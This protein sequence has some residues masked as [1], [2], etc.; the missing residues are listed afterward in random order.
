MATPPPRPPQPATLTTAPT[1]APTGTDAA[2]SQPPAEVPPSIVA[3]GGPEDDAPR[4]ER[5]FVST[6][7]VS[8]PLAPI[9]P[10]TPLPS[11]TQVQPTVAV[12]R[13]LLQPVIPPI[14][15]ER[16]PITISDP[17]VFEFNVGVGQTFTFENI[18]LQGGVRLF[19]P[20]PVDP[21]SFL[22]TDV[23]GIL[24]YRPLGAVQEVEMSASPF[25]QGF[26]GGI[27][28]IEGNKNRIIELD[29][30]ADGQLFSF[31]IDPPPGT[32][33]SNAGVWYWHP[34]PDPTHGP[35]F[36]VIR[37][38][39][40]EGYAS[41]RLVNRTGPPWHWKTTGVQ[42]SPIVGDSRLLLTLQ[43]PDEGRNALA[44]T[45]A[46][47]D[48]HFGRNLPPVTRYDYG[49]WNTDGRGIT[50]SG[51]RA[52]GFV[53]IGAVDTNLQG[54][55]IVLNGSALGLWLR[56]AVQLPNGR[57][58]ALGRPG[59]P[60]SGPVAL[61]NQQG[62][63]ISGFVGNAPPED[64]RWNADRSAVL[65][66]VQGRQHIV[67]VEGGT[68]EDSTEAT[69][70]PQFGATAGGGAATISGIPSA[71]IAGA[72]Y[73]PGQ[74]LRI[75]I[76]FLNLRAEPTTSSGIV[77]QLQLGDY[78]AI[79]AGPYDNEGYSWWQVQTAYNAFG[80]IAAT[81]NGA[82]TVSSF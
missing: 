57:Y 60:G 14:V 9:I 26:S 4:D 63:Q 36:P 30:S 2:T 19:L 35:T 13:D 80:W 74:Q 25:F 11:P 7:S 78:V 77:V 12:R 16:A 52:D 3:S 49:Y 8:T 51:R 69:F 10:P 65:V 32:D 48:P 64:V 81:I 21:N 76:P 58:V 47:R 20:N 53:I 31:R 27:A 34:V 37:D 44:I 55:R 33:K 56:D 71:V 45:Q 38:C 23:K 82:P 46:T 79:F 39:P 42:W 5:V 54:E 61:Y 66:S 43:L 24:R 29:W 59:G 68:I 17:A 28:N 22:R 67:Q 41:C 15:P 6:P 73:Y 50:V 62:Q 75:A 72:E 18:Q 1:L 70:N 40:E